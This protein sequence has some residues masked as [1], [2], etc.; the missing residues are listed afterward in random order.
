[1]K[2]RL[3][4]LLVALIVIVATSYAVFADF[5]HINQYQ[6][7]SPYEPAVWAEKYG[8]T[9]DELIDVEFNTKNCGRLYFA[10]MLNGSRTTAYFD[11]GNAFGICVSEKVIDKSSVQ[12][13][14]YVNR[15]NSAGELV[16]RSPRF[17]VESFY[18][19][20]KP[21]SIESGV[22]I[23]GEDSYF[24]FEPLEAGRITL[25]YQNKKAAISNSPFPQD[26][27]SDENRQVFNFLTVEG[28]G[29]GYI[30]IPIKIAGRE[31]YAMVDTGAVVSVIDSEIAS[32]INAKRNLFGRVRLNGLQIGDFKIDLPSVAVHSQRSVGRG[33]DKDIMVTIGADVLCQ[34]LV[35]I[36]Y[37]Q[38]LLILEH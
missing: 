25:D 7:Y 5:F 34:Y 1:M 8:Y 16:S 3:L 14:D 28:S 37:Q 19:G 9:S 20:D 30:I 15:Y 6:P 17:E 4:F 23:E 36:D 11:A 33:L 24:G 2:T 18:I 29:E 26:L 13:K 32:Q 12:I 22:I 35:T 10:V 27:G 21:Y 38:R 31:Y